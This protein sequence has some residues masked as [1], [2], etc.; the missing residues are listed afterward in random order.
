M[1]FMRAA[2]CLA[3]LIATPARAAILDTNFQDTAFAAIPSQLTGMAWAPDGSNRLFLTHK[4]GSV[5]IIKN[6]T[7][8]PTP[9]ATISPIYT[10]GECGL[11]GFCFDPNFVVNGYV[12][13]FV[14]VSASEQQ[15]IRYTAVGDIGTNKTVIVPNL[16][17]LGGNHDG[18]GVGIGADG[19]LY[20]SIG[21]LGNGSGVDANLTS[22]AAKVGRANLDGSIPDDNPFVDGPGGNNDFIWA[23]G[24]RNPFTLTFQ[25]ATG[26]LWVNC[27]GT[28]Y[29][30]IFQVHAGGHAGWN[31]YENNQ[32]PGY[33]VPK[34]KYRTNGTDTRNLVPGTGAVR[35]NNI[36]TFTTVGS[37]GFRQGERLNI[38][39]VGNTSLTGFVYVASTPASNVF[40]AEQFGSD[41][42]SGSGS[43]QT[44]SQGG[45]VT[46]GAFYDSTAVPLEYRQNFFYGDLNSGR[47]MRAVLDST[48]G[49]RS[50]D[51]FIT[52]SSQ[53]IDIAIG[54]DGA[55]YYGNHAGGLR[56]AAFT[57]FTTQQLIV[58][59]T[60]VRMAEDGISA[61]SVRL[62]AAPAE[63]VVVSIAR[64]SGD[65]DVDVMEGAS[66]TFS[67]TNWNVPQPVYVR[68]DADADSESDLAQLEVSAPG[69]ENQNVTV[70]ALD[71][72]VLPVEPPSLQVV[73]EPGIFPLE[74]QLQ[75]HL[76]STYV[77]EAATNLL[78]SWNAIST[79]TL[80]GTTT[81]LVDDESIDIPLRFYRARQQ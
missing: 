77:L 66:L 40:T 36:A 22:L 58:T 73:S 7:L 50:V 57:N 34:I 61:I 81:N 21:D 5:R 19:K 60:I 76:G 14:T 63:D 68:A 43:A 53:Q 10:G 1:K 32:P 72:V 69:L 3:L 42:A 46:G 9:F 62:A 16:P 59:P 51:Y 38:T 23:R 13:F 17:T 28:S 49:V 54:P 33:I 64:A 18:G 37:H 24:F 47:I 8:A 15:I 44:L 2:L 11:I 70:H 52:G 20:W 79:N 39:G 4:G 45:C 35:T 48:N 80:S 26:D 6:G 25:P 30:Q 27:V 67:P 56:R 78:E 75:G 31:D 41:V 65:A 74:L 12:Y 55:L 71:T 29:E